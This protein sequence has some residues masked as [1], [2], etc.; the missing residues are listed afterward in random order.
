MKMKQLKRTFKK[1]I[2]L[3]KRCYF[4]NDLIETLEQIHQFRIAYKRVRAVVRLIELEQSSTSNPLKKVKR[5]YQKLGDIRSLQILYQVIENYYK[6][7]GMESRVYL[8]KLSKR[9]LREKSKYGV[10]EKQIPFDRF[11]KD[12]ERSI[13]VKPHNEQVRAYVSTQIGAL[14]ENLNRPTDEGIHLMRKILKDFQYD[15]KLLQTTKGIE[16][17]ILEDVQR[18]K[19]ATDLL[20]NYNDLRTSRMYLRS[21]SYTVP[22]KEQELLSR[23]KVEFGREKKL[24]KEKVLNCMKVLTDNNS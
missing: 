3:L 13:L 9:I 2:S 4:Q 10:L 14:N 18:L 24:Q 19:E 8:L 12:L 11:Y 17:P 1:R 21:L 22:L 6:N 16:I 20:G 23:L 7:N 15:A 5:L